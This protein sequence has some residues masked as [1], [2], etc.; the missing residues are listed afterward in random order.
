MADGGG[1]T[2][3]CS[4]T[5]LGRNFA[6]M[7]FWVDSPEGVVNN[8][9]CEHHSCSFSMPNKLYDQQFENN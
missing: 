8:I 2:T 7:G 1:S 9:Q 3:S 4:F 5:F 6:V